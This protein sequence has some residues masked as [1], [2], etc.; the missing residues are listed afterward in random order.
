MRYG[1]DGGHTRMQVKHLVDLA[2]PPYMQGLLFAWSTG[3]AAQNLVSWKPSSVENGVP[4]VAAPTVA[5]G[6]HPMPKLCADSW[7]SGGPQPSDSP[8]QITRSMLICP[9]LAPTAPCHSSCPGPCATGQRPGFRIV[10]TS[11]ASWRDMEGTGVT[12]R[13]PVRKSVSLTFEGCHTHYTLHITRPLAIRIPQC[14]L[15]PAVSHT[16]P[17]TQLTR[18]KQLC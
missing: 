15:G 7:V 6:M 18:D 8:A 17:D 5:P 12:A 9:V 4:C 10:A 3:A 13:M 1:I 16:Y 14:M 2:L 11:P